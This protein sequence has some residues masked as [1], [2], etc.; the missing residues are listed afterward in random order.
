MTPGKVADVDDVPVT[1]D[2]GRQVA[3]EDVLVCEVDSVDRQFG[4]VPGVDVATQVGSL[5]TE[6][7][8]AVLDEGSRD[9]IVDRIAGWPGSGGCEGWSHRSV[10]ICR[11]RCDS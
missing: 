4:Q 5:P 11:C 10:R 1:V 3:G 9:G 7:A 2:L 8:G 6:R